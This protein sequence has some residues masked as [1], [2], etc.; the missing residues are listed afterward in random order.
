MV[1]VLLY[2]PVDHP[3][4]L[5]KLRGSPVIGREQWGQDAVTELGV[6]HAKSDPPGAE[7]VGIGL[8]ETRDQALKA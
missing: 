4:G 7:R 8:L 2:V 5:T 3:E 1:Q 6:G